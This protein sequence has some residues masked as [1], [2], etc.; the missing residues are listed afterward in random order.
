MITPAQLQELNDLINKNTLFYIASNVGKR[1]LTEDDKQ[2]LLNW[3]VDIGK[4]EGGVLSIEQAYLFGQLSTMLGEEAV[5]RMNYG[6]FRTYLQSNQWIPLNKAKKAAIR[7][8]ESFA[9]NEIKGLGNKTVAQLGKIMI[10]NDSKLELARQ[11]IIKK[12]STEA[13][14]RRK[15]Q[16]WLASEL[17]EHTEDWNRDW[18]RNADYIL[19]HAF[20][21]GAVDG[22]VERGGD[23]AKVYIDVYPG[24]CHHCIEKYLTGDIGSRPKVFL[25]STLRENGTNVGRKAKQWMPVIPPMHPW[26]R[27]TINYFVEGS[28]WS[29]D[30][31]V[32][33]KPKYKSKYKAKI[34]V[35]INGKTY[36][37]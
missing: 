24:A 29:E 30:G 2:R 4:I 33:K 15:S 18:N 6:E 28:E 8:L 14:E 36:S 23:D 3:G 12:K 19:H 27:C 20:S 21:Q 13:I 5:R 16:R 31:T 34:H 37:G 22:A 17:R 11:K 7:S 25:V 35:T 9:Y 1:I 10:Y 32:F 26:C